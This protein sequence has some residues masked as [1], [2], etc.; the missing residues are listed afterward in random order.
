MNGVTGINTLTNINLS[1]LEE[2]KAS[3][4]DSQTLLNL[5]DVCKVLK[6]KIDDDKTSESR[7]NF[8]IRNH[9][10]EDGVIVRIRLAVVEF[11]DQ[12]YYA[13]DFT[14]FGQMLDETKKKQ[15]KSLSEMFMGNS[16]S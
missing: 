5:L 2:P 1:Q 14:E 16:D 12:T 15:E 4:P 6:D 3:Q 13:I 10:D 11:E 9:V 8:R 7:M